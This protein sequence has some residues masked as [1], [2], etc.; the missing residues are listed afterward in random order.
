M[1]FS[2]SKKKL[3]VKRIPFLFNER[4][5]LEVFKKIQTSRV[6]KSSSLLS[7]R[8]KLKGQT[9]LKKKQKKYSWLAFFVKL[10]KSLAIRVPNH[11][12]IS[13]LQLSNNLNQS[14]IIVN[15]EKSVDFYS[16]RKTPII[17]S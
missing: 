3:Y 8:L 2:K 15:L 4:F 14:N 1:L 5:L 6:L 9:K 11:T 10:K 12:L 7:L 16:V 17:F 13:N